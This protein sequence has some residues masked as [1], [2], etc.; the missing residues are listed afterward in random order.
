VG[1]RTD[2]PL[3]T[4][5]NRIQGGT[6]PPVGFEMLTTSVEQPQRVRGT[7]TA[8]KWRGLSVIGSAP[9]ARRARQEAAR[10]LLAALDERVCPTLSRPRHVTLTE[11]EEA[12]AREERAT[13]TPRTAY[14]CRCGWHH[15]TNR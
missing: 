3:V 11:A 10:L 5:N 1:F 9:K 8:G 6:L 2:N 14:H 13:G 12:A 7:V 4:L 15:V